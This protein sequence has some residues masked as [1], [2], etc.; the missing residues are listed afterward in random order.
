MKSDNI[1]QEEAASIFQCLLTIMLTLDI[2][3]KAQS[4]RK[5]KIHLN[6]WTDVKKFNSPS[7][8]NNLMALPLLNLQEHSCVQ[9]NACCCL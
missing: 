2:V 8:M 5:W 6:L 4:L 7:N 9:W 3:G 1:L